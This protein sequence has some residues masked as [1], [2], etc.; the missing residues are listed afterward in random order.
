MK[1][2][3]AVIFFGITYAFADTAEAVEPL[4]YG[5]KVCQ[6]DNLDGLVNLDSKKFFNGTWYLTY[7]TESTRVT[8]STICRDF[9]PKIESGKIVVTYGYYEN[10]GKVNHYD[11][12]CSGIQNTTRPDIFN[13]DCNSNNERGETTQFHIDGSFL[14]TDYNN[15]GVVYRCVTTNAPLV[16][17]NVF[18]IHRQKEPK[19]E[20]VKKYVEHYGLTMDKFISR[21][22]ATCTNK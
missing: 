12:S 3:I 22:D 18:I 6:N 11:V 9:E 4:V 16:E 17:D 19:E 10:G 21:K 5:K 7:A 1:T 13:F 15:F 2:I 14:A 8:K 20:D